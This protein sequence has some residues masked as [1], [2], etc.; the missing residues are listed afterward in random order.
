MPALLL[1]QTHARIHPDMRIP[2]AAVDQTTETH[3]HLDDL[4]HWLKQLG[5]C[6]GQIGMALACR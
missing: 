2:T 5:Q 1:R 3:Q 4:L 6:G